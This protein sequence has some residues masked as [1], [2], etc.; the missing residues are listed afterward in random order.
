MSLNLNEGGRLEE[1][2][3]H[4]PSGLSLIVGSENEA[5]FVVKEEDEIVQRLAKIDGRFCTK[6]SPINLSTWI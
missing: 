2:G 1:D 5:I 6:I 4:P 3:P